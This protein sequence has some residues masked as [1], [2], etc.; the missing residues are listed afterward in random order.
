VVG[1]RP[2]KEHLIYRGQR[3]IKRFREGEVSLHRLNLWWQANRAR[4]TRQRADLC[5]RS[6]QS[7]D[8]LAADGP[9]PP[10]TRIRFM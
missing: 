5:A 7:R 9:V 1:A 8:N 3:S 4:V 6:R 10:M 2:H